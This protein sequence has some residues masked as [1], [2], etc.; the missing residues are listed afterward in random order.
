MS[1]EKHGIVFMRNIII[2]I[3]VLVTFSCGRNIVHDK[4]SCNYSISVEGNWD[5]SSEEIYETVS[6]VLRQSEDSGCR[7]DIV[8]YSYS[9]GKEVFS[10]PD[11]SAD[12]INIKSYSGRVD[13]LLKVRKDGKLGKVYFVSS[14]GDS[15]ELL[16][17]N[18]AKEIQRTICNL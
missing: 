18:L 15:K 7:V 5:I 11:S 6:S 4:C 9:R 10:Y 2:I 12:D 16:F 13:A 17:N 1:I 8:I 14:E 3:I